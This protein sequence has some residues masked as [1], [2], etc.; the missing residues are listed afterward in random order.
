MITRKICI[1]RSRFLVFVM[2]TTLLGVLPFRAHGQAVTATIVGT[3]TDPTGAVIAGARVSITNRGTGITQTGTTNS[4][5]NYEFTFLQPGSYNVKVAAHGFK[6][7]QRLDVEVPVNTTTRVDL[8]LQLGSSSSTVTV[9]TQAPLLQ[10]DRPDVSA[11][12]GTKQ[13]QELPLG[14]EQ[15]FQELEMLV[16]GVT[17][18]FHDHSSFF[19]PQNAE[20]FQVNGQSELANNTMIEGI[21]DNERTGLLQV[22]I[23]PAAAIQTVNVETGNYAPEFGRAAGAVT[24]V[25]LKSG[26]N[27][28]HGS[29]YELN[30]ISALAA[31]SYFER[32]G[33]FPRSTNNYYG[34]TLGGPIIR[35]HTFFF[36]DY[37]GYRDYS[38]V[39]NLLTVPT[40]AFRTGDFSAAPTAIYDPQTGN[41]D[42]TGRQQFDYQGQA[43]VIPPSRLDPI[44]QKLL[45]LVPLPN[46]PGAGFTNNYDKNTL[47]NVST[48]T[49]DVKIDQRLPGND[50]LNGRFSWQQTNTFQ[51]PIFGQAGGPTSGGFEGIGVNTVYN[52]A[53]N[54]THIF[55]STLLTELRGGVDHYRNT[56]RQSDY[57]TDASTQIGVPGVNVGPFESG[58]V[59]INIGGYSGPMVG[60]AASIPWT[61]AESNIE[62]VNNWT[63]IAGNHSF[64]F[65]FEFHRVRDNLTQGQTYSPRGVFDYS[66]GQ[67]ALNAPGN[68]TSFA[69]DF[70]SFLLDLPSTVGRDVNVNSASW[71][72]SYYAA[73]A[74]D[75]WNAS[76]KLTL[77][78]GMRWEFYPPST[79]DRKG[80]FSQYDPATNTL[81]IS[82]YGNN[83]NNIGM[84]T[85]WKDFE[86]RLGF[87]YRVL[88][89]T[90]VRGGFGIS[91]TQFQDNNYAYNYPVRQNNGFNSLSSYT[92]AVLPDG[93]PATLEKGF[94]APIVAQIPASGIMPVP[95]NSSSYV[96]VNIH[97][98]DPYVM[99]YNLTVEQNLGAGWTATIAYVGNQGRHVPVNYNI[100]AGQVAGAGAQGQPFYLKY[101]NTSSIELLPVGRNSNYNSL[102]ARLTHRF[103]NG[104]SFTS[105][106]AWQKSM[107]YN[108]SGGGLAGLNFYLDPRRDYSPLGW[109][110]TITST[111]SFIYELPFGHGRAFMKSGWGA[112]IAGGW[113]VSGIASMET[114]TP[115]FFSASGSQLNAPGTT[116]VPNETAPFHKLKGIGTNSAWFDSSSFSQPVGPVLGN[117]GKNVYSG[118]GTVTFDSSASRTFSFTKR[119]RLQFRADAFNVLN[120]PAFSN[121]DATLTDSNFGKVTGSGGGRSMQLSAKLLF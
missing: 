39:F 119:F 27:K 100:N 21:D 22:Y 91:Y 13:V 61:R 32:T 2:F 73:F 17:T 59:G 43:N 50:S 67:T 34:A 97:S 65:G 51:Q 11:Q 98:R 113:Q 92:P 68:K 79:P 3:V 33:A 29:A 45:A 54:Y 6:Q 115:L 78:Y 30:Q 75:T 56:A 116:Q 117:M 47:Y 9:T 121:P 84:N 103:S 37:A 23:P 74:Q 106:F 41:P 18:P 66:D 111:N 110:R 96:S 105:A 46:V 104:I 14:S 1:K 107:G 10:T 87:A 101:G 64:K 76:R 77:T 36:V 48:D 114:G 81:H 112:R 80:G 15:N 38:S 88:S 118:P 90:V 52:T 71:R 42:G 62:V 26:T 89:N 19:D 49:F 16:P 5:G 31:R 57:G 95:S 70:A 120:H 44:A 28:L 25:I 58:L 108:S 99:F 63:K 93:S 83:P 20:G 55:S 24:N 12:L 109:N 53:L 102:Q 94:P 40:A 72:Q 85:N 7:Q 8:G 60:Y 82:G 35:K 69:N 4:S 86:P